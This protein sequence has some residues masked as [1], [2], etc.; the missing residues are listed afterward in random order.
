MRSPKE[1]RFRLRQELNNLRLFAFPTKLQGASWQPAG[2]PDPRCVARRL[3]GSAFAAQVVIEA[4]KVLSGKL[5][6][7]GFEIEVDH[8]PRWRRDYVSGIESRLDY[9]RKIPYL[10][11]R[12]VGDHKNIW[13]LNRHQHLALFAMAYL[14]T[15]RRD[16]VDECARQLESW[17]V[18]NP[19]LR[20]INWT[21]ALEVAFR[22]LSWIWILAWIG[23][24]LPADLRSRIVSSLYQHGLYLEYNLSVY[25]SPNTHLLGEAVVLHLLGRFF[26]DWPKARAW[27]SYAG[28]L[29]EEQMSFQ[30]QADGVHFEQST[31]YHVY[32][33]DFFLLHKIFARSVPAEYDTRLRLGIE[34]LRAILGHRWEIPLIGDD[35]GGRLFHPY[36]DRPAFGRATMATGAA[37]F[38]IPAWLRDTA[39]LEE[40]ALWWLGPDV[41]IKPAPL[42]AASH[43]FIP[44]GMAVLV[45]EDV[46]VTFDAGPFGWAGAGHSHSDT[47]SVTMTLGDEELLVDS[48]TFTYVGN[49]TER[50]IFRGTGAHNTIRID[51]EDQARPAGPFRWLDKP[52]VKIEASTAEDVTA[53]CRYRGFTHRRRVRVE[54]DLLHIFDEVEGDGSHLIEQLWHTP[55]PAT[56][57]DE[58][59]WRIG[60]RATVTFP[61]PVE[62]HAGWRS[63]VLGRKSPV[64]VLTARLQTN[65][66]VKLTTKIRF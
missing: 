52:E 24:E 43:V 12:R 37:V 64:T 54:P 10:D 18:E 47:L 49:P 39:D 51:G 8:P 26:P 9:F 59:T 33:L 38:G 4:E 15:R 34:Y 19:F 36:G 41:S 22:A 45:H 14:F 53:V 66:P 29:V 16:F 6:L 30:M 20:G 35:D 60:S 28:R 1:I 62:S 65:L 58:T 56:R 21:S 55:L 46:H 31:Y 57:I 25:F 44:S 27:E 5:A 48:G 11:A 3:Q 50:D 13:E 42:P 2:I 40:Q 32:A 23:D 63:C 17:L 7:L 61:I